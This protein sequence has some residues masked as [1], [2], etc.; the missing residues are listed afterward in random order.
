MKKGELKRGITSL[1]LTSIIVLVLIL[2]TPA[3]AVEVNISTDK[4]AYKAGEKVKFKFKIDIQQGERVPI[5]ELTLKLDGTEKCKFKPTGEIISGCENMTIEQEEAE[6][7][8]Y[9]YRQGTGFG[10]DGTSIGEKTT[11][12]GYGYGYGYEL[13][14]NSELE[15]EVEWGTT[16]DDFGEHK[17]VLEAKAEN[18][19][20]FTYISNTAAFK[21]RKG[22]LATQAKVNAEAKEGSIEIDGLTFDTDGKNSM[23]FFAELRSVELEAAGNVVLNADLYGDGLHKTFQMRL[24]PKILDEFHKDMV[25]VEGLAKIDLRTNKK[26]EKNKKII[27]EVHVVVT[28]DIKNKTVKIVSED[29][30][31]PFVVEMK[32][33]KLDYKEYEKKMGVRKGIPTQLVEVFRLSF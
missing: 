33:K 17:A 13:E 27:D 18:D 6:N 22:L 9:G 26:G 21:I 2:V 30:E 19:K 25:E 3:E 29:E 32:L 24:K 31:H 14:E 11:A 15:Y 4:G 8:G 1:I 16:Q 7:F 12:F 10:D 28:I 23:E 20:T 5:T